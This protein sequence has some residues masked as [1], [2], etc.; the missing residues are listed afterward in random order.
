MDTTEITFSVTR[1]LSI[2]LDVAWDVSNINLPAPSPVPEVVS[3]SEV[4]VAAS[5]SIESPTA[6]RP[7]SRSNVL[8]ELIFI[9]SPASVPLASVPFNTILSPPFSCSRP[10]SSDIKL[11]PALVDEPSVPLRIIL[12]PGSE[13]SSCM[14]ES[15]RLPRATWPSPVVVVGTCNLL[16]RTWLKIVS[17][18]EPS[19]GENVCVSPV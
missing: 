2:L 16:W 8:P 15:S 11:L 7:S 1:A 10:S 17:R 4:I 6:W 3:L 18:T 9:L 14:I 19:I 12:S 5:K 13:P